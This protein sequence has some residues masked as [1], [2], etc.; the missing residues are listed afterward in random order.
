MKILGFAASNN[1]QSINKQ[2][3]TYSTQLVEAEVEILDLN[4]YEMPIYSADREIASGVPELAQAF[5]DKITNADAIVVSFAEYNGSYTSAFKNIFDWVSR[6]EQKLY[7]GKPM[8]LLSTSPGPGGAQSVLAGAVA[9]SPFFAGDVKASLSVPSF[10]DNFDVKAGKI[11]HPAL[12][13]Q[14]QDAM[15]TLTV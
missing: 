14:L 9:S 7:Q 13:Q 5:F 4:E 1:S 15:N 2:L 12:Q 3:V 11:S 6:I 10:F 8:V